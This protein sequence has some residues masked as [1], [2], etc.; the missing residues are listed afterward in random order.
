M[1][2][3][4]TFLVIIFAFNAPGRTIAS[5]SSESNAMP[6][7]NLAQATQVQAEKLVILNKQLED[8]LKKMVWETL[9][10]IRELGPWDMIW[11]RDAG[12][13]EIEILQY[14]NYRVVDG[15]TNVRDSQGGYTDKKRIRAESYFIMYPEHYRK[16]RVNK[17]IGQVWVASHREEVKAFFDKYK[18]PL[19]LGP[20][21]E[22]TWEEDL[23]KEEME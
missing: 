21:N 12:R 15:E 7:P 1:R 2:V 11:V 4:F 9:E 23:R 8:S 10:G 3:F 13:I 22:D 14:G 17:I 19:K 16:A 6:I 5:R 20:R 18:I